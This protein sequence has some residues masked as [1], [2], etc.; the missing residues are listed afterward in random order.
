MQSSFTPDAAPAAP[1]SQPEPPPPIPL[2]NM[3]RRQLS[4]EGKKL[5]SMMNGLGIHLPVTPTS[6]TPTS[7]S[8]DSHS[9]PL[10]LHLSELRVQAEPIATDVANHQVDEQEPDLGV[11]PV[12]VQRQVYL[13]PRFARLVQQRV[14]SHALAGLETEPLISVSAT[15]ARDR[16]QLVGLP[17]A[18]ITYVGLFI[19][20]EAREAL[21][22]SMHVRFPS[23]VVE[24]M[25]VTLEYQPE[26]SAQSLNRFPALG[27]HRKVKVLGLG[28]NYRVQAV[29]VSRG[30]LKGLEP[31]YQYVTK[32]TLPHITVSLARYAYPSDSNKM[33]QNCVTGGTLDEEAACAGLELDAYIGYVVKL[34]SHAWPVFDRDEA[35]AL[36]GLRWEKALLDTPDWSKV[37]NREGSTKSFVGN[38]VRRTVVRAVMTIRKWLDE[39]RAEGLLM[40]QGP[41]SS[42]EQTLILDAACQLG[43]EVQDDDPSLG[44]ILTFCKREVSMY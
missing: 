26:L 15:S 13:T 34:G 1:K 6:I 38:D 27:V 2:P 18:S 31:V 24:A 37:G 28:S 5:F 36:L 41:F 16:C 11:L 4:D 43:L 12:Q 19:T 17:A 33:L 21:L 35:E 40:V 29:S 30:D 22:G 3:L 42:L 14:T 32:N 44:S 39:E 23:R 7:I 9:S 10:R 20:D 25:H 8:P